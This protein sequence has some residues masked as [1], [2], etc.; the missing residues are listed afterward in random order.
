MSGVRSASFAA[1]VHAPT[2]AR[3]FAT[4]SLVSEVSEDCLDD[5]AVIVSELVTNAVRAGAATVEVRVQAD[6][7]VVRL[8]VADTAPGWP[9]PREVAADETTGRGLQIVIALAHDWGVE[10]QEAGKLV[11]ATVAVEA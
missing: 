11:W 4:R 5:V 7:D 2:N 10:A 1:D 3:R 9:V 8:E 6:A